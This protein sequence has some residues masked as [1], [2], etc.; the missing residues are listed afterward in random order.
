MERWDGIPSIK[1][2]LKG[3]GGPCCRI[4]LIIDTYTTTALCFSPLI[5]SGEK[6]HQRSG[7]AGFGFKVKT[8]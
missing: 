2:N 3:L 8:L 6:F 7:E 4:F 1:V 5:H